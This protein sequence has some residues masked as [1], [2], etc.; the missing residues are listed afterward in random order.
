MILNDFPRIIENKATFLKHDYILSK[1]YWNFIF[2][3]NVF[4]QASYEGY[5]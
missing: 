1:V 2:Y 4:N 3:L 5:E